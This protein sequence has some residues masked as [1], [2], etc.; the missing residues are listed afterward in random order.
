MIRKAIQTVQEKYIEVSDTYKEWELAS[1]KNWI[2]FTPGIMKEFE[3]KI[4]SAY[5]VTG[6]DGVKGLKKIQNQKKQISAFT[7]GSEGLSTGAKSGADFLVEISGVS[8]F[9]SPAD[10]G[11]D[12]SRNGYKW[13]Y[14]SDGIKGFNDVMEDK[15]KGY[16]NTGPQ[17]FKGTVNMMSGKEKQ[18]FIKWYFDE[19]KKLMTKPLIKKIQ[20]ALLNNSGLNGDMWDNNE[21][22]L[23]SIKV[24]NVKIIANV[25]SEQDLAITR[26]FMDYDEMEKII[27]DQGF[28]FGGYQF[29]K[30]LY[31]IG[32]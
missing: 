18:Q 32:K 24:K 28:K 6:E 27:T 15:L 22:F 23:H 30:Y 20:K 25:S 21:L 5:H 9:I 31:K 11:S 17:N 8:S 29:Q 1:T 26:G 2:P 14:F 12:L 10:I 16:L 4:D 13:I 3:K 7:K 19:A